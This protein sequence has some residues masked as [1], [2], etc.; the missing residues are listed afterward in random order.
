MC[1]SALIKASLKEVSASF[2]A[3]LDTDEFRDL[4]LQRLAH[5]EMKI[6]RGIDR[7]FV[8]SSDPKEA[9][10]A[11]LVRQFHAEERE[12]DLETL[13]RIFGVDEKD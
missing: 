8:E 9:K 7:Y 10:L 6:P 2:R 12:R 5:P 13:H 3:L 4:F 1:Y 11:T